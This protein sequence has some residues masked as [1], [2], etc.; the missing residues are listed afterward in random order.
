MNNIL[1]EKEVNYLNDLILSKLEYDYDF[2]EVVDFKKSNNSLYNDIL[3]NFTSY[4]GEANSLTEEEL[5]SNLKK[6]TTKCK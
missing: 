6:E 1:N 2:E 3:N 5:L 4:M